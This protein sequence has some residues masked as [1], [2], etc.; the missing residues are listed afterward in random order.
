MSNSNLMNL[1]ADLIGAGDETSSTMSE[2]LYEV[3][4]EYGYEM[5]V[6]TASI[7][8]RKQEGALVSELKLHFTKELKH[9]VYIDHTII[10]RGKAA[11]VVRTVRKQTTKE[12]VKDVLQSLV[13]L[14]VCFTSLGATAA[15]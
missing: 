15:T 12:A 1:H 9:T 14:P 2:K 10:K 11:Q 6:Y 4:R 5:Q 13:K 3:L 7:L 8:G